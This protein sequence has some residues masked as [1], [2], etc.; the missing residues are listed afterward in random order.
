M[1]SAPLISR[2]RAVG[3]FAFIESRQERAFALRAE[4]IGLGCAV[5]E[6]AKHYN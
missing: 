5:T 3:A 6:S 4:A 1:P 2:A